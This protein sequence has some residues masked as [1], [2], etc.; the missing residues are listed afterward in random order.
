[1]TAALGFGT[2]AVFL[3]LT[4]SR[5]VSVLVALVAVPTVAALIGGFAGD[6][7]EFMTAGLADVAPVGILIM[8]AVFYFTLMIDVGLFDPIIKTVLRAVKGDPA[9][10]AVGT[11]VLTVLVALD[12]D[13]AST[14]LITVSRCSR[15]ISVS[16]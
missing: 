2:V 9:K 10:I 1:M 12:G 14:F 3:A 8:F 5:R 7:D 6:L 11:V 4:F 13:G 15:S 16:A